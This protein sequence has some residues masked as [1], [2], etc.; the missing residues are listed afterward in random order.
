MPLASVATLDRYEI[1]GLLGAGGMD[2]IYLDPPPCK[3]ERNER[4]RSHA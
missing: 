1:L 2:E 4:P 3:E